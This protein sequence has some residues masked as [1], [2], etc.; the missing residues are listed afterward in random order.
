MKKTNIMNNNNNNNIE[1]YN[2]IKEIFDI[3]I[4]KL[5]NILNIKLDLKR[6]LYINVDN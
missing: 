6:K 5:Y 4:D 1:N 2:K 3:Y